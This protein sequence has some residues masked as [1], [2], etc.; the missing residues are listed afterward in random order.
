M[1]V[2]VEGPGLGGATDCA[3]EEVGNERVGG[4]IDED[5]TIADRR[6]S[7]SLV[8][9]TGFLSCCAAPPHRSTKS[10]TE[11]CLALCVL[12]LVGLVSRVLSATLSSMTFCSPFG[13]Y[14]LA[15]SGPSSLDED[16]LCFRDAGG[17]GETGLQFSVRPPGDDETGTGGGFVWRPGN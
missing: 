7:D 1:C 16:A 10:C 11:F 6:L 12:R 14:P 3:S 4:F 2:V 5:D 9:S 13:A 17:D 15:S 8:G